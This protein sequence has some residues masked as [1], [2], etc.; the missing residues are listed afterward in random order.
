M[1]QRVRDRWIAGVV[2]LSLIGGVTILLIARPSDGRVRLHLDC[3]GATFQALGAGPRLHEVQLD[4]APWADGLVEGPPLPGHKNSTDLGRWSGER[5]DPEDWRPL[6]LPNHRLVSDLRMN[7]VTPVGD[8]RSFFLVTH[9]IRVRPVVDGRP[10]REPVDAML[11][12]AQ[13]A[14]ADRTH[15]TAVL[16]HGG[17]VGL[18]GVTIETSS[19]LRRLLG[20][21]ETVLSLELRFT[22][23]DDPVSRRRVRTRR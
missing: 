8:G 19:R 10:V 15:A 4:I 13:E 7:T 2:A 3:A 17:R 5:F 1:L 22:H 20:A 11:I 6:L 9:W 18:E 12:I 14:G 23:P 21:P 16:V